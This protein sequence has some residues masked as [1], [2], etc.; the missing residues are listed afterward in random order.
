[1]DR[2]AIEQL[3]A[4][5]AWAMDAN[6]FDLLG[7]VFAQDATHRHRKERYGRGARVVN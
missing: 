7:E 4:D 6:N 1:M 2:D 5:Y 3:Y